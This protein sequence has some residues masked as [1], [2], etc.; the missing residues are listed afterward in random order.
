MAAVSDPA[1][2]KLRRSQVEPKPF[3]K[4]ASQPIGQIK[5]STIA[6]NVSASI[7]F[8]LVVAMRSHFLMAHSVARVEGLGLTQMRAGLLELSELRQCATH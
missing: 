3:G 4:A 8:S 2:K 7:R 6:D 1:A 5:P